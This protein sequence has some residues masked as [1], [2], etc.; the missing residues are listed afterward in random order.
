MFATSHLT[1]MCQLICCGGYKC[2]WHQG[3]ALLYQVTEEDVEAHGAHCED[4]GSHE[5]PS[6]GTNGTLMMIFFVI[7]YPLELGHLKKIKQITL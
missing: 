5:P 3:V 4:G 2:Y 6:H 7:I 1:I